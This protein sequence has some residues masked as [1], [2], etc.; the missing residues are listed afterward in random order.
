L[1]LAQSA[2]QV[3]AYSVSFDQKATSSQGTF[4]SKVM[5]KDKNLRMETTVEGMN[6]V[7]IRNQDGVFNYMPDS[8]TAMRMSGLDP[9]Q[10]AA[11]QSDNYLGY[12]QDNNAK[13]LGVETVRG[14]VCDV[15]E[16]AGEDG[17]N[18][19]AWVWKEKQFPVQTQTTGPD[20]M[21]HSEVSN[22]EIGAALS[23]ELFVLPPDVQVMDMGAL[24]G[25]LGELSG[26]GRAS[27][28]GAA[29]GSGAGAGIDL[30]DMQGMLDQ[31]QNRE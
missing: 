24:G 12:L 29:G 6:S 30:Q 17:N 2:V 14:Y 16:F 21:I 27:R 10:E 31:L 1:G 18:T 28:R 20:G 13:L 23:D 8:N 4:N 3:C 19:K 15:F 5:I 26:A 11:S 22:I 7:I 25:L 9:M